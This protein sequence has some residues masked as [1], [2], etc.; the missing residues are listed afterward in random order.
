MHYSIDIDVVVLVDGVGCPGEIRARRRLEDGSWQ[1]YVHYSI[2]LDGY[3]H[4]KVAWV[5]YDE[6]LRLAT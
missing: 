6:N 3:L 4:T 1:A 5:P 2:E